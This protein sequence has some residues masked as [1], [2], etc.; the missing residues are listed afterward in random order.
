MQ[1]QG[2]SA[3]EVAKIGGSNFCRVF[4]RVTAGHG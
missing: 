3:D 1:R 2:F 4:D